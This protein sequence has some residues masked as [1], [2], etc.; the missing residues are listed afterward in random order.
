MGLLCPQKERKEG[1]E[2]GEP[3]PPKITSLS[4]GEISRSGPEANRCASAGS[5]SNPKMAESSTSPFGSRHSHPEVTGNSGG[6]RGPRGPDLPR[7][8]PA[9]CRALGSA[10]APGPTA[11]PRP[12]L[13]DRVGLTPGPGRVGAIAPGDCALRPLQSA[14]RGSSPGA[15]PRAP[16]PL[17]RPPNLLLGRIFPGSS[18]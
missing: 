8:P 18:Y 5:R 15:S 6:R 14:G 1:R 7:G 12:L 9:P 16:P 13:R 4:R 2:D 10:R 17:P 11:E 3:Q